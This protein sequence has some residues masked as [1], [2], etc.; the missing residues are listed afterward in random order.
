MFAMGLVGGIFGII[1]AIVAMLIGGVDAAFSE[2]GTSQITGL[3][4][5]AL[6]FSILGIIGSAFSKSKPKLAGWLML[7]SGIAGFISI[8]MFYILSGVLLIVAGFMGIFS[9]K[10]N[11]EIPPVQAA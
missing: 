11:K 4:V 6:L 2:S 9:K 1:A 7:I 3:A 8:S 10:K 5:S